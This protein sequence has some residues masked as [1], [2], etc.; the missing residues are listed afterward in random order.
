MTSPS[1]PPESGTASSKPAREAA[2]TGCVL[3]INGGSSSIK[4]AIYRAGDPPTRTLLGQV[5]RIGQ[6][7]AALSA[8]DAAGRVIEQKPLEAADHAAA[9]AALI[10]WLRQHL[11]GATVIAI[12]HRVVHGGMRL[13]DHQRIIEE[14][15]AELRRAAPVDLAHLPREIALI[16]AFGRGFAGVPQVAC[17]DTAFHRNLPRVAQ[18]LPIPR[19]FFEAGIRRLGFHGLSY[20]YLMEELG[21]IAP[22]EASGRV[23]LAHLGS[24][25]SMAAV[26]DRKS[27]DTTMA[28]TPTAGLVMGTR[29]GDLDPG[30]LVYLMREQN[31]TPEQMDEFI[32]KQCGLIGLSETG[33]DMRD[34]IARR[35]TDHR[36][37]EAVEVFCYQARKWIGAYAAAMGGLD[38]VVFS[39][40]IGEHSP[41]VRVEIC[42]G[43]EFLGLRIDAGR[44]KAG[45]AVI[46]ADESKV[47]VRVIATDEESMIARITERV[48]G[49]PT[50]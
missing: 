3:T 7:G 27:V 45:A 30:L 34:L 33:A 18:L 32:S 25:A 23:I 4:F 42:A 43:L 49:T 37:A 31:L 13:R 17:L 50:N 44:N 10:D 1:N 47:A 15:L 48:A 8:K 22:R 36:A 29:P 19:K 20:A 9:A 21:R 16:E 38:A 12:G 28:F 24:G 5:E 26:R 35:D 46:S 41:E 14:V 11:D 39:G 6:K 40:G 2:K